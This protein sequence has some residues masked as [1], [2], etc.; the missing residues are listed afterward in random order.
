MKIDEVLMK[1]NA[2]DFTA[3]FEEVYGKLQAASQ[4]ARYEK[5]V[6]GFRAAFPESAEADISIF[7]APGRTEICG[8]HTD[9]QHGEVL[10]ASIND[11]AIAVVGLWQLLARAVLHLVGVCDLARLIE[12]Q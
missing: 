8:N 1:I 12:F 11:D 9:H 6:E 3:V 5:A 7:S 4:K 10:A 2:S